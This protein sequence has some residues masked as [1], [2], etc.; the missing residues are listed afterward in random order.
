[1]RRKGTYSYLGKADKTR[2]PWKKTVL[3]GVKMNFAQISLL[4]QMSAFFSISFLLPSFSS[5]SSSFPISFYVTFFL[6]IARCALF[7]SLSLESDTIW[8][9]SV[10][11]SMS[12]AAWGSR[13]SDFPDPP[14]DQRFSYFS[15]HQSC[16]ES[17]LKHRLLASLPDF[18]F[19]ESG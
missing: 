8:K 18:W 10:P 19:D 13:V 7:L 15:V 1:M 3:K 2:C 6:L 4:C 5:S 16:L 11:E 12:E 14:V 17:L 9:D